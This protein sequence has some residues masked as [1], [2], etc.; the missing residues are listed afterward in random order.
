MRND[1]VLSL[2][3]TEFEKYCYK[4][5]KGYAEEESLKD[6]TT[7]HN[8]KIE[9]YDGKYQIDVYAEFTALNSK[10]K[11]LCECKQY[12]SSIKRET[13]TALHNK[14][15]S[16]G[17]NKGIIFSTSDFQSGAI[18]Y[19][20]AHGIALLTVE[21]N[22]LKNHSFSNES[23]ILDENDPCT[24]G[25]RHMPPVIASIVSTETGIPQ[26][27]YPT[28]TMLY[29]LLLEQTKRVNEAYGLNIKID[30]TIKEKE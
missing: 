17:A 10:I 4:I 19:A 6:F 24:Y 16:I 7:T 22:I 25:I 29:N 21:D 15:N 20:K 12:T 2:T 28:K 9:T 8:K 27:I 18:Q 1:Y 30:N 3:P 11:V 5:L 14:L 23:G 26:R 13:V